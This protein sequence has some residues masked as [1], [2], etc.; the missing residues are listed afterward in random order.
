MSVPTLK[1]TTVA[2][3]KTVLSLKGI[4]FTSGMK[5][6]DLY[7][8]LYM[9]KSPPQ[10][11]MT[12]AEIREKLK[13]FGAEIPPKACK[14]ELLA[15]LEIYT[16]KALPK[17][18]VL[19]SDVEELV[20]ASGLE[21]EPFTVSR[22][23]RALNE[24]VRSQNFQYILVEKKPR[25]LPPLNPI[26]P[27][28]STK[29]LLS[30]LVSI[31]SVFEENLDKKEESKESHDREELVLRINSW[32]RDRFFARVTPCSTVT[33]SQGFDTKEAV[34]YFGNR[35]FL[36]IVTVEEILADL[37]R[38]SRSHIPSLVESEE[39]NVG[40]YFPEE[41]RARFSMAQLKEI[42][43]LRLPEKEVFAKLKAAVSAACVP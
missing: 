34:L 8:L 24:V 41:S 22:G 43:T 4:P 39:S 7:E 18:G 25:T 13:E 2:E 20:E 28:E 14:D 29:Y 40:D 31:L 33:N 17:R 11:K 42:L 26:K 9:G 30:D 12:V 37:A 15:L 19:E 23:L 3:L 27:K 10:K 16:V 36:Q 6:Q 32:Y 38:H 35:R 5:K 21:V 1:D